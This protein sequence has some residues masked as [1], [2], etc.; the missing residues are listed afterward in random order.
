VR[1]LTGSLEPLRERPFRLL[2]V[3]QTLSAVGD[4][5]VPVA[6][7]FA[8]LKL[9]GATDLGIV[10][11]A[12]SAT[13]VVF[14]LAG[15]VWA[16]RL[17]RQLVMMGADVVRAATQALIALA[18]YTGQIRLWELAVGSA[19]FGGASAFFN[20]ASTGLLPSIVSAE[21]LQEANALIG[22]TRGLTEVVGPAI[23]GVV[24]AAFGYGLVFAIDA[25]SFVASFICLAAMH[26]PSSI[27]RG[28]RSSMLAEARE[29]LREMLDRPW[30]VAGCLC[31]L[32]TNFT[33]AI[34]FVLGPVVVKDHFG[35]AKDWG[36]MLTFGAIGGIVGSAAALRYKP[37]R[38]LLVTYIIAFTFP[39][40][41]AALAPP[42][43]LIVLAV[44]LALVF[45]SVTLGN[46]YWAT[47]LQQHVPAGAL[48]R[49]DSLTWIASLVV[50][51]LGLVLAGP[52]ASLLG[53]RTT[54]LGAA[55]LAALAITVV[56]SVRDVRELRR[57]ESDVV[58]PVV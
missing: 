46:A 10:L 51:P 17:P 35:G 5:I 20:P 18:F 30:I 8:V 49:V 50:F 15:G 2:F 6:L 23:A 26:L 54:L 29:G 9:G 52:L 14:L 24:V 11:G 21:R 32:V 13:R 47:M 4:A 12:G 45:W 39:L 38:P 43:P 7:T 34:L 42:L 53:V 1:A 27:Q 28:A 31:D 57:V 3:G 25:A 16:D 58:A 22:L 40:E 44:G 41:L 56:L 36:L 48:S 19:V 37:E 33:L 55:G